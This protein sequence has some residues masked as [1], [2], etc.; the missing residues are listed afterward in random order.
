MHPE[1]GLMYGNAANS[2]Y[3][4][5]PE[6][7]EVEPFGPEDIRYSAITA[8]GTV[9]FTD[10]TN[11][12]SFLPAVD[13]GPSDPPTED[14]TDPAPTPSPTEPS[15]PPT[16]GPD[17]GAGDGPGPDEEA[18]TGPGG[19]LPETGAGLVAPAAGAALVSLLLGAA[20]VLVRRRG[21]PR[22]D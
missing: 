22:L 21:L 17:E 10:Q 16:P 9:Y 11:V 14:P 1:N 20:L 2:L 13:E 15:S 19:D 3:A 5:D 7:A 18:G 12:Y 8:D 6:T 4:L